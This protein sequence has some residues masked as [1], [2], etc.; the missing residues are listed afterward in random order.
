MT[1]KFSTLIYKPEISKY[2]QS[3][4]QRSKFLANYIQVTFPSHWSRLANYLCPWTNISIP[5]NHASE[6]L[7][8]WFSIHRTM[9]IPL[10]YFVTSHKQHLHHAAKY[11]VNEYLWLKLLSFVNLSRSIRCTWMTNFLGLGKQDQ[12]CLRPFFFQLQI[13]GLYRPSLFAL[14]NIWQPHVK[15]FRQNAVL[16]LLVQNINLTSDESTSMKYLKHFD[17]ANI[18][19]V[20]IIY[21]CEVYLS[22]SSTQD[23]KVMNI[24]E[25]APTSLISQ[26]KLPLVNIL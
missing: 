4:N 21:C 6:R 17:I 9:F 18:H 19:G 12:F 20:T 10:P 15:S 14:T 7:D 1:P 11:E 13:I 2:P 24:L 16:S 25:G 26:N 8:F 23:I 3:A 5:V 22:V